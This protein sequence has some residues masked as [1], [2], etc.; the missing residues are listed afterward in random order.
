MLQSSRLLCIFRFVLQEQMFQL[1]VRAPNSSA[2]NSGFTAV[3]DGPLDAAALQRAAQ[4]VCERQ[5]SLRTLF[6]MD[7]EAPVQRITPTSPPEECLPVE[8][9]PHEAGS[10]TRTAGT[11]EVASGRSRVTT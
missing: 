6:A 2:Y 4:L 11:F 10:M 9:V 8:H 5:Q 1:W 3:L 7:G